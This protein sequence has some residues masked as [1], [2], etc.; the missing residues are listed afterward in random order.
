MFWYSVQLLCETFLGSFARL[1]KTIII[2]MFVHPRI[3][4]LPLHGFSW[5][6]IFK[7]FSK[8]CR[9]SSCLIKIWQEQ[10]ALCLK[11]NI[12]LRM[13]NIHV[14]IRRNIC[15]IHKRP[16]IHYVVSEPNSCVT[17]GYRLEDRSSIPSSVF[18]FSLHNQNSLALG[19][20]LPFSGYWGSF[21]G[22][23]VVR[24]RSLPTPICLVLWF[25]SPVT[26]HAPS[27]HL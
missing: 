10:Q 14:G 1:R 27:I 17:S 15:C 9:E 22:C 16:F 12:L 13:K 21:P 26:T 7:Y 24:P 6:L 5:N 2:F 23:R 4:R 25:Q 11:T 8:I 18:F 3:T 19:C 20:N